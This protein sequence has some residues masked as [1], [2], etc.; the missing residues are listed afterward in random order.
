M[1]FPDFFSKASMVYETLAVFLA[2]SASG[3]MCAAEAVIGC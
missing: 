3:V 2:A 1:D